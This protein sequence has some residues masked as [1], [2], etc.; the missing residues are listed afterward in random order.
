[1]EREIK[2]YAILRAPLPV[3]LAL[4]I[5]L[6]LPTMVSS[7]VDVSVDQQ[8]ENI[9][10]EIKNVGDKP[11]YV[12][13]AMTVMDENGTSVYTSQE[14]SRAELLRIEPGISYS[15]D[16][17]TEDL[18]E[19]TYT[20]RIYQGDDRR[21]L[22]PIS[23]EFQRG[24]RQQKPLMF[25]GKKFYKYGEE[26]DVTFMNMGTRILYVNVNNWEVRN[27]DTGNMVYELSQ[28]CT[29]GY[30]GCAD[31]FEPLRFLKA[32]E[33]TWKQK[34]GS[35][36]QVAPGKY[37]VTAEYSNRDPTSGNIRIETIK[38]KKF[39]IRP[40]SPPAPFPRGDLN[41]NGG[42]ADSEDLDLMQRASIGEVIP[43]SR[44]DLNNNGIPA[45]AGDLVLMKRASRGE[46]DLK[47]AIPGT[48]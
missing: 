45:D 14:L 3:T 7:K 34:D 47:E 19:G 32:I 46:I 22:K 33:K 5:I 9:N 35:G 1:M 18:P 11:T 29:F 2:Q 48:E 13:N 42:S 17:N 16:L 21:N 28:D 4:L 39:Y 36:N 12:I 31:S 15:F 40:R 37:D 26:I 8:E 30:G 10:F 27:L 25:T 20:N 41:G 23:M 44:Y 38:T 43:D 24:K 6:L